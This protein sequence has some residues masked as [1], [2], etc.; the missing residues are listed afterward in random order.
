MAV[1][2]IKVP[3]IGD[4]SDVPVIEVLVAVGDS[5][6]K[7]QGLVTLES[8]KATLEVPSS[9]AGVVK[10]LKVKVGDTLSEGALVLLLE[11]EGEAAAPAKAEPKAAP[12]AAAPA[13]APGSKPPVTPSHRAPAEPA[14]PK[15]ALASG[16]PADIECKM[17]VLGAG[18]GGYTAAFRAADLGLDTV[19]IERY[20]SLGGV[21][22]NVGCIPSKALLHAAAVIDEVAHAGDFG[23]D[24]GQPKITLD[25]LREYK[26]KVVGKLTGGLASMAKQRKVRT[27]TGVAS[28][29]S[30]NELEIVGDDGKTQLLRFEHCIIAAGSQAV[31]LPNFPWDDKRVMD[32]TDALELHDIPKTLLV[33]GGGIIG[34]EM[35]T[36]Y[37]ALGSKVTVV[38]FMDQLMP[39]ADKDLVKPL[40][41]S[42][43]KQGVEV[44]LKTKA[45]DVKADKSGITVS[46]EAAVEGEKPGLQATAYDR[47]LVAVG[48]SPNGKKIGAEKAGVTITERGFIPVD[49]QMRTNVP[50]IF[51]IGDIVGNPMLAHKATHEGKLAADVA[52]GEKKEWV[53]RVIP[54]VAYTNPEIAWVGVTETEAKAKGLK[55]GVAK[56]PWAASGRAIGIGR[57]EGF[58]KLIFD[59]QT[60]RVIGGAIVGVHAGDL[61]AEIGLAI[62]M[63]AEA[64][65]IGHTI[66]AHPT[67]SES[68]G[69]AAEVYDGTITDLYIPKKK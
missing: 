37:S 53:A 54:S 64:E 60:H 17:V 63:G 1:I 35:A 13:A 11:T 26:E 39:G 51:A 34:L 59:E 65:D 23:V 5:V 3:D 4:Y 38:E 47:V 24:F 10:E 52:A 56:F 57:T 30:P 22:L 55:V 66:H 67:L 2:E 58:T 49:R 6:A 62:E 7:D 46:F 44:H 15:P 50:H 32:S 31:K 25:K 16:K 18:P 27:V 9:A 21:C 36:V 43:K 33:V 12:A 42:L 48:R 69:M 61:L 40:A 14:A 20:A 41:D 28:F 29:V 45:T 19:L 8:D 68:V